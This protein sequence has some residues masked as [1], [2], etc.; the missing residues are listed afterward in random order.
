MKVNIWWRLTPS[1]VLQIKKRLLLP[2]LFY[3]EDGGRMF[4]RNGR[5]L[6]PDYTA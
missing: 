1:S 4:L 5:E 6:Q 3:L 2:L